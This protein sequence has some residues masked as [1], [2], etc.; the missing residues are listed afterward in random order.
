MQSESNKVMLRYVTLRYVTLCYVM[1]CY[2]MLCY[3][4][5]CYV[6]LCY[7]MLCYAMFFH[8]SIL[9]SAKSTLGADKAIR[10]ENLIRHVLR[11]HN[12]LCERRTPYPPVTYID[13]CVYRQISRTKCTY[14]LFEKS[15][16]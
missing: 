7:V 10:L 2:V 12:I 14:N 15:L 11:A 8:P 1:L 6:M 13:N 9:F 4:M 16:R 5:L 3:V